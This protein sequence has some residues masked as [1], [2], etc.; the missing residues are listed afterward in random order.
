MRTYKY[1]NGFEEETFEHDCGL[2]YIP[3]LVGEYLDDNKEHLE[4][5]EKEYPNV[6]IHKRADNVFN[7]TTGDAKR[8]YRYYIKATATDLVEYE[9]IK[10][11]NPDVAMDREVVIHLRLQYEDSVGDIY[12]PIKNH[13]CPMLD[14]IDVARDMFLEEPSKYMNGAS[15]DEEENSI[16]LQLHDEGGW[17]SNPSIYG[18][19]GY[20]CDQL[21]MFI[22]GCR[23]LVKNNN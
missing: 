21:N 2:D 3:L 13:N 16:E 17:P 18:C 5:L 19:D 1:F 8:K 15:L 7:F 10:D 14:L 23:V 4:L 9:D 12:V 22:T 20:L 6:K 11:F